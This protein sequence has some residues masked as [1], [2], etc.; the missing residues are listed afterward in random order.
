MLAR[1]SEIYAW[2][3][4]KEHDVFLKVQKST[5]DIKTYRACDVKK[6]KKHRLNIKFEYTL[7]KD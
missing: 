2:N 1:D 7:Q 3:K 4:M 6:I 5:A